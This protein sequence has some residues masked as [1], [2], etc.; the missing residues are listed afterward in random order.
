[1]FAEDIVIYISR[2]YEN[3]LQTFSIL[4]K[5]RMSFDVFKNAL[6]ANGRL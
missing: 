1:M 5:F 3:G 2:S 4:Q 6:E